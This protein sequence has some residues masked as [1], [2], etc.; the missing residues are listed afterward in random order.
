MNQLG[1]AS[2]TEE[3]I[4]EGVVKVK[5]DYELMRYDEAFDGD[6][7]VK[8]LYQVLIRSQ[9][10]RDQLE[11][12]FERTDEITTLR[13]NYGLS[14]NWFLQMAIPIVRD[15]QSSS[16][17]IV[18]ADNV[19][20]EDQ[21]QLSKAVEN[22]ESKETSGLGAIQFKIT[23]LLTQTDFFYFRWA[24]RIEYPENREPIGIMPVESSRE[25]RG[26]GT[27]LHWSWF[28]FA[29]GVRHNLKLSASQDWTKQGET[30]TGVKGSYKQGFR[31][32]FKYESSVQFSNFFAG[33]GTDYWKKDST[34]IAGEDQGDPSFLWNV[35]ARVG[36]GSLSDLEE[37]KT[38]LPFLLRLGTSYPLRGRNA[39]FAQDIHANFLFYF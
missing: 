35:K 29:D 30:L 32:G 4:P 8:P 15:K 24:M 25:F 19:S 6:R 27:L 37:G 33:A 26:V 13:I 5:L 9:S 39:P 10:F 16:L 7:H 20:S 3:A 12:K 22:L 23:Q 17:E 28:P 38:S 36:W 31:L 21:Q 18:N 34:K 2:E 1:F 14:K 11:G